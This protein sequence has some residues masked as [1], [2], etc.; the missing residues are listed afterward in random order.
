MNASDL[1][2]YGLR[3]GFIA[4]ALVVATLFVVAVRWS[5]LRV[6]CSASVVR[7]QTAAACVGSLIWMALTGILAARGALHF[8]PP[9]TMI[10]LFPVVFIIAAVIAFSP[11]GRR[12]A[13][14]LPIAALVGYQSFR[15]GVEVLL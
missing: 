8:E 6:G 13:T 11:L 4:L 12:L 14:G 9:R 15:V 2:S 1:A 10:A 3:A 7:R 5:A